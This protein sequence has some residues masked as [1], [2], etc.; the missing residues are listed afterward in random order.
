MAIITIRSYV[1]VQ[2]GAGGESFEDTLQRVFQLDNSKRMR[3]VSEDCT[4]WLSRYGRADGIVSGEFVR[5]RSTN[6]PMLL[7]QKGMGNL[8]LNDENNENIG[9]GVAFRYRIKDNRLYMQYDARIVSTGR[10]MSYLNLFSNNKNFFAKVCVNKEVWN[11]LAESDVRDLQ[12]GVAKI[13]DFGPADGRAG[14]ITK[15][16][17]GLID[18]LN[19]PSLTIKVG[20]GQYKGKIDDSIKEEIQE[21]LQLQED[22]SIKVKTIRVKMQGASDEKARNVNMLNDILSKKIDIGFP[23]NKNNENYKLREQHLKALMDANVL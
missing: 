9:R 16:M 19:I 7:N 21:V 14:S 8:P 10:A 4:I 23:K 12:I 22:G 17:T 15:A 6:F 13:G 5:V 20:M 11:N 3:S 2:E 18:G 1:V